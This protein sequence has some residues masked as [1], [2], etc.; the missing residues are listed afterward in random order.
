MYERGSGS[1]GFS[2]PGGSSSRAQAAKSETLADEIDRELQAAI[3]YKI[4]MTGPAG[5][6]AVI[7]FLTIAIRRNT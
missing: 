7:D 1:L 6:E 3:E 2:T 5:A 4:A